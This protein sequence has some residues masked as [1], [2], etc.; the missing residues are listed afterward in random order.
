VEQERI[1]VLIVDDIGETRENLRKLLSFD[2][3]IEVVGAA[4]SGPEG[5]EMAKEFLPHIV[6]MDINMP[7]MDGIA[8]TEAL[9]QE[10]PSAQVVIVSVQGETDYVRRAMLAGARDF[11][12]KPP[13]GD[14]LMGTIRRV[15]EKGQARRQV[16][17]PQAP[18]GAQRVREEAPKEDLNGDL[19]AVFGPKGGVG[20]TTVAV[21]LAIALQ[22]TAGDAGKVA[23]VDASLQFGDVGVML[24]LRA[25]RSIAD[26]ADDVIDEDSDLLSSVVTAHGSGIKVLLA[27]P[28]PEAAEALISGSSAVGSERAGGSR[29]LR[30]ILEVAK[31]DFNTVVV[32][33]WSWL[34]DNTLTVFDEAS[35]IVLVVDTSI[36]AIKSARLF[37]E[38]AGK[39]DYSMAKIALVVNGSGRRSPVRPEQIEQALIPVTA[40]I[41]LDEQAAEEAAN[42]G[43]PLLV[44]DRSRP[45]C[46][47]LLELAG[48]VQDKLVQPE[49]TEED[50]EEAIP[51]V[52][53]GSG[54]TG[55]LRLRKV[56]EK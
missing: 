42:R 13:S 23:L 54:G 32:D 39:L 26:L 44:R 47:S 46:Q 12:T 6:L 41:P 3:G 28:H 40:E 45:I 53:K 27:P 48:K 9:L 43:V 1:K 15:H 7:D 19:I 56:F 14:E 21:N 38:V 20:C 25:N 22:E 37:L 11:L 24:N 17:P 51:S 33:T 34:D 5:I 49:E 2:P 31:R 30:Q 18:A 36:P 16:A 29:R 8:A 10:V 35:L 55:L 50:K 52:L 4:G